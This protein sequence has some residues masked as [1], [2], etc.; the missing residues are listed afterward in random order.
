MGSLTKRKR[1]K[2]K[3]EKV[4]RHS[5]RVSIVL[6]IVVLL[7]LGGVLWGNSTT[8]RARY[9]VYQRQAEELQAQIELQKRRA[10]EI[11]KYAE[12]VQ[13]DE[14]IRQIAEEKLGLVDPNEIIFRPVD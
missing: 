14:F 8:L 13:S 5:H 1:R 7:V 12:F 11:E 4:Y 6:V 9:Q 10:D 2:T 3:Q